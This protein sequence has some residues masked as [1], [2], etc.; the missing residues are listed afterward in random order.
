VLKIQNPR[1]LA[2]NTDTIKP[3]G[4]IIVQ[5]LPWCMVALCGLPA[6]ITFHV[7]VLKISH[8]TSLQ[9]LQENYISAKETT[10]KKLIQGL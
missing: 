3:A 9:T 4:G 6:A 1:Q 7:T 8:A 2:I 10:I 5:W